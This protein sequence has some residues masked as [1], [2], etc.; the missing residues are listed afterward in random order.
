MIHL[1]QCYG[2]AKFPLKELLGPFEKAVG[3]KNAAVR[4]AALSFYEECYKWIGGSIQP[5]VDKLNKPQQD[6]LS[7]LFKKFDDSG[8]GKP[9]ATRMTAAEEERKKQAEIDEI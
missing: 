2:I 5:A 6:E 1:I 9:K 4:Q 3:S 8:E 7:K